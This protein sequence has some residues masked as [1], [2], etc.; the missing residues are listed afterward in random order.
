MID[1][2]LLNFNV[3]A[4]FCY[5]IVYSFMGWC[6][7]TVYTTIRKKEFV[8]RGFL[9]GPFCPIYGFAILSIIVLLKPIENNYIF[10]LLGSIFL[11][12][13]IE[14]ITGYILETTFDSTWWDY[15]DEPYNLHGRICLKFSIL[16]GFISI[17][18]LKVIHP[19]IKYIVNLIPPNPG[20]LLFYITLVYFI[21]DFIITII[22]IL[23]LKSL[24][25]QLITAYSELTDKFLDF[26]SNLGNT[27]SIPEL[28][29]KLDQL[30]DLAETKMSRNKSNIENIVKEVKIKYDSL[31][32]KKYPDYS[33]LIKAFPDLK[34][35]ALDA[36]FKDVKHIIHKDKK[37]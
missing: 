26:K 35:K 7:E 28:R 4:L 16:W 12:S 8:N 37:G 31:F 13:L 33:R 32:I 5:F 19:Y 36:I 29:I 30:I 15:S 24:L 3:F 2:T 6:L 9:H 25:T 20:V 23:K 17:L 14:Y 11:T 18:I 21:L 27:K 34:F 1:I 10:L 22:T